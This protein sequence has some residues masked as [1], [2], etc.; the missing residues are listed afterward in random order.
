MKSDFQ[1]FLEEHHRIIAKVCRIY[2][3]TAE[4]FN[5]YYQECV[6]QLWRSFDSFRGASKL[7]TWVY[8]VCLNVC[9][10]QLRNKKKIVSVAREQL[11]DIAEEKDVVEEEQLSMLY[12]AIKL[13][14]ESDRAVILLYLEEKSYK[15]MAEILG[16]TVTNVGAKVN[17]VKNQLKKIID[18]RT[19]Y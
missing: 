18:G 8:R 6:I 4:D 16:I 10:S 2:T 7:S 11:P 3:D 17:R 14:K 1:P 12:K 9:L 13:L 5:D 19:G 15:E